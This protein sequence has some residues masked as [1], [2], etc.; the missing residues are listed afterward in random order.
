[1][2]KLESYNLDDVLQNDELEE[3]ENIANE[4]KLKKKRRRKRR[5]RIFL[6]LLIAIAIVYMISDYANIRIVE[7]SGNSYYTKQQIMKKAE[8]SY[9][10][11]SVLAPGFLIEN[12][13]KS[14]VLIKNATVNKSWDGIIKINISEEKLVGYYT[15]DGKDYLI[16]DGEEDVLV[17]EEGKLANV[18][19]IVDLN[20]K[21]LAEYKKAIDDVK[22]ENI[23]L[24]SEISH[25][26]TSYNENMLKLTMQDG[27]VV[28]TSFAGLKMLDSYTEMLKSLNTDLKCI[29]FAEETNTMYTEKCE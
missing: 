16:I 1:M 3:R 19:Y 8:I 2:A 22:K 9:D 12:R 13:L 26:E 25:Y 29:M 23:W 21:Q 24:I 27:H 15:K 6:F 28:Y 11:K 20:Q 4:N 5:R 10:M 14:D 7:L 18:P 17:K